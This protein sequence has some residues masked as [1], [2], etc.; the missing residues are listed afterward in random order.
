MADYSVS[1]EKAA[2]YFLGRDTH[3]GQPLLYRNDGGRFT[4]VSRSLGLEAPVLVMGANHGDVDND[5]FPDVYLGTGDPEFESLL[6]NLLL[7]NRGA[8]G[9]EEATAAFRLGYLQKGH[10][11]AFGD[12]D[13]DGDLDLFHQL[14]GF[15]P[16]DAYANALFENPGNTNRWITLRLEGRRANR[17]GVGARV[18]VRVR[19]DGVARSIHSLVGSGGSFGGSSLQQEIGLGAAEAVEEI[20]VRWPGS[21]SGESFGAA[22]L[23]GTYRVVEGRGELEELRVVPIKLG[24]RPVFSSPAEGVR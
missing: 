20:V 10:G 9:F 21:D 16:G 3:E 14:G 11:V 17:F 6:P 4:E 8:K 5:G 23:D 19:Q 18:T 22:A 1:V 7:R 15:Y 2:A 24:S 13:N 12:V